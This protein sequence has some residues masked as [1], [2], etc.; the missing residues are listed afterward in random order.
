[1]RFFLIQR[2]NQIRKELKSTLDLWEKKTIVFISHTHFDHVLDLPEVLKLNP[3][4]IVYG[5]RDVIP[6]LTA[7]KISLERLNIVKEGSKI[8]FKSI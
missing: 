6:I 1:M 4:A 2:F 8:S 3:K 7:N 5:T